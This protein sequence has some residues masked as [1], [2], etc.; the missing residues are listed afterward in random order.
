MENDA[1][2]ETAYEAQRDK[3]AYE[4]QRDRS[5]LENERRKEESRLRFCGNVVSKTVQ[6][7]KKKAK[8]SSCLVQFLLLLSCS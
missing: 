2:A 8:V 6:P 4:A 1:R 7:K 3:T 5:V